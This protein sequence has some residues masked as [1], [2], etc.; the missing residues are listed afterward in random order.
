M[1]KLL[2]FSLKNGSF[3]GLEVFLGTITLTRFG[4]VFT[5][6]GLI[7]QLFRNVTVLKTY[8]YHSARYCHKI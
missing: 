4:K 6:Y 5:K 1:T 7:C 8:F 2:N 3:L